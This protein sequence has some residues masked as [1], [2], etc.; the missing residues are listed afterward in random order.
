M[1]Q[2]LIPHWDQLPNLTW[3]E[4]VGYLTYQFLKLEQAECPVSH[5]FLGKTYTRTMLIPA[6]TLFLGREHR[7]GHLCE[8]I[9]GSVIYITPEG[10]REVSAPYAVH[11]KPGDHMVLYALT[12]VVGRTSHPNPENWT[13][14]QK[15]EDD[16]FDSVESLRALGQSVHERLETVCLA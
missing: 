10:R 8:L 4:K 12:D 15:L 7:Y 14:V 13:D 16:I 1:S 2:D 6:G 3:K 5:Q 9:E 11:T